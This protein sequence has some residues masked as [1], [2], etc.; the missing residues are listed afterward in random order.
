MFGGGAKAARVLPFKLYMYLASGKAII[1]QALLSTPEGVPRPPAVLVDP[2]GDIAQAIRG[3]IAEPGQAVVL[4]TRG[5][6]Y[7][8]EFLGDDRILQKWQALLRDPG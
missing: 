3:L 2:A 7:F 1:T 6:Q 8:E 5:R 4:G